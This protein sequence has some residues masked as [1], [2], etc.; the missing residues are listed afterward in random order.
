MDT[1]L[2][3]QRAM[4]TAGDFAEIAKT[5]ASASETAVAALSPRPGE[6]LLDVACGTGNASLLAAGRG[7]TV[8]GLDLTPK[9]LGIARERAA[10]AGLQIEFVE[11]NAQELPY[12]D[13]SFDAAL[14]VFG[15]MFAPDHAETAAELVRVVRPGRR[16]AVAAWTPE[17]LNGRMFAVTAKHTPPPPPDFQQPVLWGDEDHVRRLFA[18]CEV[19]VERHV[20][21]LDADSAE[22]WMAQ[23][24][25]DLGPMVLA[26]QALEPQGKWEALR[27]ELHALYED[28]NTATDGRL[29]VE[30]EY[31]LTV[32]ITPSG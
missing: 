1:I 5:I 17:G 29:H 15:S 16:I 26:R 3:R 14:S 6:S 24:E 18:G 25:R 11:G 32:A 8:T 7:A 28:A 22:D 4:W 12:P 21:A 9:L 31:L 27:S 19:R 23:G 13:A 20:V 30:A 2:D 10:E